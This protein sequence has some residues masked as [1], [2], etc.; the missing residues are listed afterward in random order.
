MKR[1][2]E[3]ENC[4]IEGIRISDR[5]LTDDF[6]NKPQCYGGIT[7]NENEKETLSLPPRFAM[8]EEIRAEKCEAEIE[9]GMA[10]L[11]GTGGKKRMENKQDSTPS[12]LIL[13]Q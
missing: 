10:K 5:P 12:I 8:Y 1:K 4:I 2:K 9:K 11:D 13:R 3:E 7:L 6:D